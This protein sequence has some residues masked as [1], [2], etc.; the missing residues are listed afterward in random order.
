MIRAHTVSLRSVPVAPAGALP[1]DRPRAS[2]AWLVSAAAL[3][4]LGC[5][6]AHA[7]PGEVGSGLYD[8]SVRSDGDAC[9]PGRVQGAMG[10]VG[11]VAHDDVLN[12][13]VPDA[14]TDGLA[15]LSL[16][17]VDG[18]HSEVEVGLDGCVGARLR[19]TWTVAAAGP[20]QFEVLF[21]QSWTGLDGCLAERPLV[22]G[23]PASD[24]T[25][26]QTLEYRL[27]QA[28]AAPCEVR[29]V[30]GEARCACD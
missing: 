13:A 23:Q 19:R 16:A 9:S 20:E 6:E 26:E 1:C 5:A 29:V 17:R 8:L 24:C 11:I 27:A 7:N 15:R 12:V 14:M 25:S 3:L 10:R 21:S 22:A 2:A 4:A 28:C 30:G 18:F